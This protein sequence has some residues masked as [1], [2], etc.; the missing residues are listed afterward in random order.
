MTDAKEQKQPVLIRLPLPIQDWLFSQAVEVASEQRKRM[1]VP[2]LIVAMLSDET[3]TD[4]TAI[5]DASPVEGSVE[6]KSVLVRL[7]MSVYDRL[8]S[9]SVE[10]ARSRR[11]RISVPSLVVEK[12]SRLHRQAQ[13]K[14]PEAS[15]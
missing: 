2:S 4:I 13:G 7:P 14:Q 9:E 15:S 5:D 10:L 12:L 3:D 6:K 11:V 1:S 8:F